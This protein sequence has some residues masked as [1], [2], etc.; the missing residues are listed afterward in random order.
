MLGKNEMKEYLGGIR[1]EYGICI[2]GDGDLAIVIHIQR[3]D[4]LLQAYCV[5]IKNLHPDYFDGC[6]FEEMCLKAAACWKPVPKM[7]CMPYDRGMEMLVGGNNIA[8]N[9]ENSNH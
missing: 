8:E 3:E 5:K 1:H 9:K 6:K 2:D 7:L 4:C